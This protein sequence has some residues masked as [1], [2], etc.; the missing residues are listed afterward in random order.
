V[1]LRPVTLGDERAQLLP[2]LIQA[3]HGVSRLLA[4]KHGVPVPFQELL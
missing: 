3:I 4:P 2:Y 1:K